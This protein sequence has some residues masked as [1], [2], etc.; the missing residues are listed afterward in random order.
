MKFQ[1][2]DWLIEKTKCDDNHN[3]LMDLG[4][5]SS[6]FTKSLRKSGWLGFMQSIHYSCP[7]AEKS[8]VLIL[9]IIDLYSS[10]PTCIY[11]TLQYVISQALKHGIK[12]PCITFDQPLWYKAIAIIDYKFESD[13]SLVWL[14]LVDGLPWEYWAHDGGI[15]H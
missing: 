4:W 10:D 6:W 1:P 14:S 7:P 9:P 5:F 8:T 11:S 15:W 13:L 3:L 2:Y 12:T